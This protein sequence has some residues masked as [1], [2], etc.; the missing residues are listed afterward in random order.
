MF[1]TY[2]RDNAPSSNST[3]PADRYA[4][5]NDRATSDPTVVLDDDGV[6]HCRSLTSFPLRGIDGQCAA[7]E[8]HIRSDDTSRADTNVAGVGDGAVGGDENVI[9]EGD[10]VAVVAGERGFDDDAL[11]DTAH[12][13]N[14]AY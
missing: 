8:I 13:R 11:A 10:V 12:R 6:S 9:T 14:R 3:A 4:R 7:L 5:H 2:L 1:G